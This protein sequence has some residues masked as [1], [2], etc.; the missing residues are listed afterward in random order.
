MK[1]NYTIAEKAEND[2]NFIINPKAEVIKKNNYVYIFTFEYLL[3][4]G[5]LYRIK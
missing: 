3:K 5:L 1:N 2:K 4:N